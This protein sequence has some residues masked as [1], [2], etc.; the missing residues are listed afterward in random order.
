MI[1]GNQ[2]PDAGRI[3]TEGSVSWPVGF[4]GTFHPELTGVQNTRFVARIHGVDPEGLTDFVADFAELG[5]HY[6]MPVRHPTPMG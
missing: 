6:A 4:A 1:A 2:K 3:V 5:A